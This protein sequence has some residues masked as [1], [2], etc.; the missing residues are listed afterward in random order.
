MVE[1]TTCRHPRRPDEVAAPQLLE[2]VPLI[3]A[4][5]VEAVAVAGAPGEIHAGA[6]LQAEAA[7]AVG[8]RRAPRPDERAGA[9]PHIPLRDATGAVSYGRLPLAGRPIGLT[10]AGAAAALCAGDGAR[11][12]PLH[13]VGGGVPDAAVALD[14]ASPLRALA[15]GMPLTAV[16]EASDVEVEGEVIRDAAP[17]G[18]ALPRDADVP[19]APPPAGGGTLGFA[20]VV[21]GAVTAGVAPRAPEGERLLPGATPV[22]AGAGPRLIAAVTAHALGR[23]GAE[24]PRPAGP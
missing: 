23:L 9:R 8:R 7:T 11:G 22:E 21:A 19:R 3:P 5:R 6:P 2:A 15:D 10:V 16:P 14:A 20:G 18:G 4:L 24:R 12:P 1:A 13:P 17:K